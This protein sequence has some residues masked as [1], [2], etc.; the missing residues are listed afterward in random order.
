MMCCQDDLTSLG[1][2]KDSTLL[3]EIFYLLVN[4]EGIFKICSLPCLHSPFGLV[5]TATLKCLFPAAWSWQHT[6]NYWE[7]VAQDP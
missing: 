3:P 6:G 7:Q 2:F 1:N 5:S 4:S